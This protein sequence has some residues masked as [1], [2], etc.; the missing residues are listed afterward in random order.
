[1]GGIEVTAKGPL[2][3]GDAPPVVR[4]TAHDIVDELVDL[5]M[6]R[7]N[8]MLRPRPSGVFLSVEQAQKGK[9]S[10]GHYRRNL[11]QEVRETLGIISDGNTVY[12][13]WLEGTGSRNATSRFKGY[14]SFRR[15]G[16]WLQTQAQKVA[17][18]Y[19]AKLAE[20]LNS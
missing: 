4:Q 18:K 15:V 10:Q 8:L 11:H 13:P 19:L 2:M 16:A 14:A 20:K 1:M 5:G 9:A 12:G 3:R 6:T 17:D 7:L